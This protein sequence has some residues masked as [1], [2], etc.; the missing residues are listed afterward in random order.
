ML[1]LTQARFL[2]RLNQSL[3]ETHTISKLSMNALSSYYQNLEYQLLTKWDA[4]L[5]NDFFAM[6]FVGILRKLSI[7]WCGAENSGLYC[8]LLSEEYG[9]ISVKP[10]RQIGTMADIAR[11][12][13]YLVEQLNVGTRSAIET[14]LAKY[15]EL[16][17]RI[18]QYLDD[19]GCRCLHELKLESPTLHNIRL[20][21]FVP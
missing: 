11:Q 10:A 1:P 12:D 20:H 16:Q 15:P 5:I 18:Q 8:D 17:Q 6:V 2:R 19:F 4:P 21:C 3:A 9:I 14:E 13:T 7:V